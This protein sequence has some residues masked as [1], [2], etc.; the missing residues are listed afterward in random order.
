MLVGTWKQHLV[1]M[2]LWG[3]VLGNVETVSGDVEC[4]NVHGDVET[5]SGDIEH[6]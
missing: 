5:L 1:T 2:A 6:R 3:T 4:G